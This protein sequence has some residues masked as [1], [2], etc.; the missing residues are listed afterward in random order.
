[1]DGQ[2]SPRVNQSARVLVVRPPC[3]VLLVGSVNPKREG[4]TIWVAPGGKSERGEHP[5]DTA[6]RELQEET[7]LAVDGEALG[8]PV[9]TVKGP[10]IEEHYYLLSVAD[11]V[12]TGDNPVQ[13]ERAVWVGFRWWTPEQIETTRDIIFPNSLGQLLRQL[14]AGQPSTPIELTW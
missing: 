4:P 2:K 1:M 7:G 9:A 14:M 11:L 13:E 5:R 8:G 6:R 3:E 12:P 10:T